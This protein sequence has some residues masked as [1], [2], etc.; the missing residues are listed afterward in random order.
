MA[1]AKEETVPN[2]IKNCVYQRVGKLISSCTP[3]KAI[4]K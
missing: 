3:S 1:Q 4:A 2:Q